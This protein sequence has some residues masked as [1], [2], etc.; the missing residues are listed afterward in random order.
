MGMVLILIFFFFSLISSI[1]PS[2]GFDPLDPY[3][4]ITIKW[5]LLLSTSG[6]NNLMV[7]I[8]NFQQYRHVE[9]PGWKLNWAWKG[10]E[11]IWSMQGAEATEQGNCTEFKGSTL[12]HCCEKEPFIV[13]LLPGTNYNA[14]TQNCCKGGVLSSMKQDPSKYVATFQMAVG[15]SGTNSR[16]RMPENFNLGVPGYSCGGA[17]KVEPSRYTTDGGRRWT[18][19]IATWNV[20]CMYSQS[21]ASPTPRCCVSLSAFYNQTIVSCPRCSCGCQGQPGTKCVKYGE[22]PPL[23][24]QNQ[25][26]TPVVRCSE[27]MCPIR[28]HWHLKQSYK[29]YWRAKMTVTNFNIM[30]NYSEWNLVVLHP[31]LQSL[32]Q[33]FSFNY[34]P[35]NRYGYINDTGMF[36]G[37]PFYNDILLQEGKNGNL[38]TEILLRKDPEIFTFRE[39][40]GF[41][42]KIQFNGDECVMP[43]PDEYPSLP[44]KGLSASATTP[45]IILFS[46][47]LAF[48][49]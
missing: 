43:P 47:F 34:A 24:K 42:R 13:D 45:F 15:G 7:S 6:T 3:G 30:K 31:N 28:V 46:L 48:M 5:D 22:T 40:W 26:P 49:L 18:Q 44:N 32:T 36:W 9:P 19:A 12:P 4:N 10:K 11:V 1:S 21:L 27:H 17:V 20:T 8:Y 38:Q 14:Q 29:Q 41:P 23:L 37:L 2:Y 35:L 25:D 16:F 33:V 39:G